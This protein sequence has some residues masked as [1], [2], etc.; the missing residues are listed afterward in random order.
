MIERSEVAGSCG[1]GDGCHEDGV[2]AYEGDWVANVDAVQLKLNAAS[3]SRA[4]CR[5]ID[6]VGREAGVGRDAA[7]RGRCGDNGRGACGKDL[8]RA[9]HA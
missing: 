2:S 6:D 9:H 8:D 3:W 4:A 7:G 5:C 1:A